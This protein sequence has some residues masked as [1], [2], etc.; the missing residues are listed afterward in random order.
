MLEVVMNIS[1]DARRTYASGNFS[2]LDVKIYHSF[3][4]QTLGHFFP[5][6]ALELRVPMLSGWKK[7]L[8]LF[9]RSRCC[10]HTLFLLSFRFYYRFLY[11]S[12]CCFGCRN[13]LCCLCYQIHEYTGVRSVQFT[14]TQL[15]KATPHGH[16]VQSRATLWTF[17][18][19]CRKT[20][21][22]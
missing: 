19:Y 3:R 22:I 9:F 16:F 6:C 17:F 1:G 10:Y 5:K 4:I 13:F 20:E 7:R 2:H 11:Y 18:I 15:C 8:H 14:S 21:W 12:C